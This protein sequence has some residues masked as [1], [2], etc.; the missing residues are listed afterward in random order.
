[1]TFIN[2]HCINSLFL[3]IWHPWDWSKQVGLRCYSHAKVW[4]WVSPL[5]RCQHFLFVRWRIATIYT[6]IY[7][8]IYSDYCICNALLVFTSYKF[9]TAR[10]KIYINIRVVI[11]VYFISN[12]HTAY[13]VSIDFPARSASIH[14]HIDSQTWSSQL[15][16]WHKLVNEYWLIKMHIQ[17]HFKITN[18]PL[19][20]YFSI[21]FLYKN[22]KR[23]IHFISWIIRRLGYME[24]GKVMC[25]LRIS[26]KL[27][28]WDSTR[29]H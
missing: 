18:T 16:F 17:I 10:T 7:L 8:Y 3:L 15:Q 20:M 9:V 23:K 1:M 5:G 25:V 11:S 21:N 19:T 12:A 2:Y 29:S 26:V 28:V 13:H 27:Q 6:Y 14:S 4:K 24:I 22:L